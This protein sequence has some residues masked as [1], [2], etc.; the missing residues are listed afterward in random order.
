MKS[1]VPETTV[2]FLAWVFAAVI[3]FLIYSEFG[4]TGIGQMAVILLAIGILSSGVSVLTGLFRKPP[5]NG[6]GPGA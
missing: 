5:G 1:E 3:A 6:Y 4:F 2:R